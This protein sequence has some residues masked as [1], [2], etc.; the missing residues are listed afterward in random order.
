MLK[1]KCNRKIHQGFLVAEKKDNCLR[2]HE[3][4]QRHSQTCSPSTYLRMC[5][6]SNVY[7]HIYFLCLELIFMKKQSYS[8]YSPKLIHKS[9]AKILQVCNEIVGSRF[10]NKIDQG[11]DVSDNQHHRH[12]GDTEFGAHGCGIVKRVTYGYISVICHHYQEDVV[13]C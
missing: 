6:I 7:W 11:I 12:W 1:I 8:D 4:I 3:Q 5:Y 9:Q 10:S 2:A 13:Q